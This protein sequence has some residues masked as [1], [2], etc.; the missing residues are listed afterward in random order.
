VI[1]SPTERQSLACR[2]ISFLCFVW[3]VEY[4]D[5]DAF[6]FL[7]SSSATCG[8]WVMIHDVLRSECNPVVRRDR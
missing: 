5:D 3:D 7:R 4:G 6:H 8:N 1:E 2:L